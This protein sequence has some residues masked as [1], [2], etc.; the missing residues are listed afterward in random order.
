MPRRLRDIFLAHPSARGP[1]TLLV[2]CLLILLWHTLFLAI[3]VAVHDLVIEDA[4]RFWVAMRVADTVG[5]PNGHVSLLETLSEFPVTAYWSA[6]VLA[7]EGAIA[8]LLFRVFV[9]DAPKRAE[10][11]VRNWWRACLWGTV[12]V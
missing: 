3:C 8:Y 10:R 9:T 4:S 7:L 6:V 12:L 11:F 1:G 2:Q 5:L